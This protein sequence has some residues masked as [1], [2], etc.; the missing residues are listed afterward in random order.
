MSETTVKVPISEYLEL[1]KDKARLDWMDQQHKKRELWDFGADIAYGW[2]EA[3]T[4]RLC[5]DAAMKEGR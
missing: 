5:I 3:P 4:F 1:Q 2:A